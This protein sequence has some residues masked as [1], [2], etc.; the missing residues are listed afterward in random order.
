MGKTIY[1]FWFD[2]SVII[3]MY[4]ARGYLV[5]TLLG[6]IFFLRSFFDFVAISVARSRRDATELII[7]PCA[8]GRSNML[9]F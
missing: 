8:P 6:I 9:Y 4:D 1:A 5:W 7:K 2:I 3:A